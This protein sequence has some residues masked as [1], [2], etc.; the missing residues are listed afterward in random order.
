MMLFFIIDEYTDVEDSINV[1]YMVDVVKDAL[2]DPQKP[3]PSD[4]IVLG[5]VARQ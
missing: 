2:N 3:R 1:G 5:E 4:E